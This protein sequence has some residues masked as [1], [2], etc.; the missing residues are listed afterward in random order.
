MC[1][2]ATAAGWIAEQRS[3]HRTFLGAAA[4][5][6]RCEQAGAPFLEAKA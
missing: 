1:V 4:R 3:E 2:V 6:T 5:T